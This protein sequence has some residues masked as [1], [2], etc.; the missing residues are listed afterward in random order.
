M[1]R[2][3]DCK[4]ERDCNAFD[5]FLPPGEERICRLL[6]GYKAPETGTEEDSPQAGDS[7]QSHSWSNQPG[8]GAERCPST[9]SMIEDKTGKKSEA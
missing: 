8:A 9:Q 1:N 2:C 5:R 6:Q 3:G 4:Y 7:P